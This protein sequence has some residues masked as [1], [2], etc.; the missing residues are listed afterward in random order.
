MSTK[1]LLGWV[2][3][4]WPFA[5]FIVGIFVAAYRCE[6]WEGL[7]RALG[8]FAGIAAIFISIKL[9]ID[10]TNSCAHHL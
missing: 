4:C 1:C 8:I 6:G 2:L 5:A 10:L 3:V 7:L 9:G